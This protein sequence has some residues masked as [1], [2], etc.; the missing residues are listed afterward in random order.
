MRLPQVRVRTLMFV[1]WLS[2]LMLVGAV[3]LHEEYRNRNRVEVINE[4]IGVDGSRSATLLFS[5]TKFYYLGPLPIGPCA[6][7]V[8]SAVAFVASIVVWRYIPASTH[9]DRKQT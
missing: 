4:H 3:D 2:A 6:V 5:H 8:F 9:D 1:V 7:A